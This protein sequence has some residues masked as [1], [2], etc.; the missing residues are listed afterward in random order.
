LYF[1]AFTLATG[2]EL[3]KSDGTGTGTVLVKDIYQGTT[4]SNLQNLRNVN[5]SLFFAA[6]DGATGS[7]LWRTDGTAAGTARVR[8]VNAISAGSNPTGAVEVGGVLVGQQRQQRPTA[9]P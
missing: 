6:N 4:S 8:D 9:I 3:W 7:E 5:G 1:G 2:I